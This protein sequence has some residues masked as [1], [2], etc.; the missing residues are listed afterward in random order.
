MTD[1]K[2]CTS[3]QAMRSLEGGVVRQTRGVPRWICE[4]CLQKKSPSI[5]RNQSGTP[6]NVAKI[7]ADLYA[8][9]R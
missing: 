1:T 7:M 8:R 3:C 6:A 2:F 9:Q 4:P 5:Y